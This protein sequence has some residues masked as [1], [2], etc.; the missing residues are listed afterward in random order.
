VAKAGLRLARNGPIL[1]FPP[2]RVLGFQAGLLP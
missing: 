2:P 1:Y